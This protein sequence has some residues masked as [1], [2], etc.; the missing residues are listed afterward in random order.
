[1]DFDRRGRN[2]QEVNLTALI[3]VVFHILF[4]VMLTTSFVVSESIELTLPSSSATAVQQQEIL[5]IRI[6][7]GGAL[8]VNDI[9]LSRTGVESMLAD[10]IAANADAKIVIVSTPGVSV[11]ELIAVMDSVYLLGGRNVQVDQLR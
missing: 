10:R 8:F 2:A 5:R 3:D 4:F 9:A 1:M 6:D 7:R 11:Q